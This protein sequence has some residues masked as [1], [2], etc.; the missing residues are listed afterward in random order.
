M[1][2]WWP[3][4]VLSHTMSHH[5][6]NRIVESRPKMSSWESCWL[7]THKPLSWAEAAL[8]SHCQH[9]LVLTDI[10]CWR[11]SDFP[12]HSALDFGSDE[13]ICHWGSQISKSNLV[14]KEVNVPKIRV[15]Y[16]IS[17]PI[18]CTP[19]RQRSCRNLHGPATLP[20]K[21]VRKQMLPFL[22]VTKL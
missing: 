3:W 20:A 6:W 19:K 5:H 2:V 4:N 17:L 11:H 12:P 15:K 8:K 10:S 1:G 13:E 21:S 14:V 9:V 16:L 7:P 18:M 22:Q